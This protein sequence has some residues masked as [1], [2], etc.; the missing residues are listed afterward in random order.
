[1]YLL[2]KLAFC[3][4][5]A[6]PALAQP[7]GPGRGT[8]FGHIHLNSAN[9][10]KAIAFWT[11]FLGAS[12]YSRGPLKGIIMSG[13]L[14]LFDQ[15]APTGASAGSAIDRIA[16]RVPD[17]QPYVDK[18][19]K[20]EYKSSH[21]A[22]DKLIIE[23][24][25][26]VSIEMSEDNAMYDP[27]EYDHIGLSSPH[28]AET[29]AWYAKVF[30]ARSGGGEEKAN[31]SRMQGGTLSFSQAD[32]VAPSAGRAIDHIAFEIRGLEA[33]CTKLAADGIKFDTPY[34]AVPEMK[35]ASAFFTDAWGT[36]IELTEG[37]AH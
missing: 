34:H 22:A 37:L 36:R 35:M 3:L 19:A 11:D 5:A 1:M 14:I 9:P 33:F 7:L 32:S 18:L 29:Q 4:I 23:G 30:G 17:F 31:V 25:D 2:R 10:D 6:L 12:T 20:T 13:A 16:L 26:G 24:P 21:P 27:L 8:A 15:R 28:A